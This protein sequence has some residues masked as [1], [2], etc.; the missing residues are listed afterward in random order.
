[1]KVI[2]VRGTN[3]SG[4]TYVVR[5]VMELTDAYFQRKV[6]LNNGVLI[7]VYDNYVV[8][9]SYDRACGGCDTIKTPSLVWESILECAEHRNVLFEG[10][11]VGNV[12]QP[13]IDLVE[14][15]SEI[16]ATYIPICLD[17]SLEQAIANVNHRRSLDGKDPIEKIVNIETNYKK[18]ISSA[19]KLKEGGYNPHWVSTEDAVRIIM[20]EFGYVY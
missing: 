15:L 17:T 18:H 1:M 5:K 10:V 13:T 20:G 3:G 16:D 9:G 7:N 19:K 14:K 12:Y 4:K 11:I 6:K 8:L 2:G